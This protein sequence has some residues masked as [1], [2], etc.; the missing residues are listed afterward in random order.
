MTTSLGDADSRAK[1]EVFVIL[2]NVELVASGVDLS[3]VLIV[4][5]G[6]NQPAIMPAESQAHLSSMFKVSEGAASI[7]A[8][9]GVPLCA[10]VRTT[11]T[12]ARRA[13]LLGLRPRRSGCY[14]AGRGNYHRYQP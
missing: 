8:C 10:S 5:V 13:R 2:R 14:G 7:C 1:V 9:L 6:G 4:L 12:L 11:T 3:H